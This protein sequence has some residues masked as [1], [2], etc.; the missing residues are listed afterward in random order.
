MCRTV[1]RVGKSDNLRHNSWAIEVDHLEYQCW[2]DQEPRREFLQG[3]ELKKGWWR[4]HSDKYPTFAWHRWTWG[5]VRAKNKVDLNKW[6][7][8]DEHECFFWEDVNKA[9]WT[10]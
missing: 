10:D 5:E 4:V 2:A 7:H 6:L 9:D 1:R 3:K 8:D